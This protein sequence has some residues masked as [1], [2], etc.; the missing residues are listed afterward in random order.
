M[1]IIEKL[2][3]IIVLTNMQANI[4]RIDA[5]SVRYPQAFAI[6]DLLDRVLHL[7]PQHVHDHS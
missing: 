6:A 4:V 7:R 5:A 1:N 2:I 3:K